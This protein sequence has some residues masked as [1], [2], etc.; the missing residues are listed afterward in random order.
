MNEKTKCT[1]CGS[2]RI[3]FVKKWRMKSGRSRVEL[4]VEQ[5]YCRDCKQSFRTNRRVT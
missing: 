1:K 5:H 2:D 3:L 4:E